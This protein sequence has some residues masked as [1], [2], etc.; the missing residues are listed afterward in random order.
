[1]SKA[2]EALLPFAD[3][4]QK[5][6]AD[7]FGMFVFLASEVM[8]F[9]ALVATLAAYR[10]L[11]PGA[12]GEAAQHLNLGLASAN[13][14]I[15]LTSSLAVAIGA[16]AA[17]HGRARICAGS[18]GGAIVLGA[19]FL[20]IKGVEYRLDFLERL[21]PRGGVLGEGAATL[22]LSLY[23]VA[24]ALHGVHV[25]IGIGLLAWTAIAVGRGRLVMPDR[26]E[27]V[28]LVGLYWHLVDVIWVFLFPLL[29]L[30][31]P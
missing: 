6:R 3:R 15:L 9:G 28:E 26:A 21:T 16:I 1:M 19:A 5:R 20:V 2:V 17:R 27:S 31:R 22:F 8:L 18:L 11:H 23:Y 25:A 10:A 4:A 13:T 14:A 7:T 12:A 29:Y 30:A 24:T